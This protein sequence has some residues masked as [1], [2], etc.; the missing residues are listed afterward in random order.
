MSAFTFNALVWRSFSF[1]KECTNNFIP[2]GG[3]RHPQG[4]INLVG[5]RSWIHYMHVHIK[6]DQNEQNN[7]KRH[8]VKLYHTKGLHGF[9]FHQSVN[10]LKETKK[11]KRHVW[12]EFQH[13]AWGINYL[14][15]QNEPF[16]SLLSVWEIYDFEL[17]LHWISRVF[18][19]LLSLIQ[20]QPHPSP[21]RITEVLMTSSGN[22]A[23]I[24]K[25]LCPSTPT[26]VHKDVPFLP[27]W[28]SSAKK[29]EGR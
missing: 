22:V 17:F 27:T 26:R 20:K 11:Q 24:R 5:K 28:K 1:I 4:K 8:T 3:K 29:G 19:F 14:Q 23:V 25:P 10:C 12:V 6:N 15:F 13:I 2:N 7:K 16:W 9:T 21:S 18:P